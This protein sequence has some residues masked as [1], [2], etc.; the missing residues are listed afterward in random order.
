MSAILRLYPRAWRE[1][2]GDELAA[3]LE[4]HPASLLDEFDLIRGALDARLHP[5]VPG[6]DVAPEQEIPMNQRLLGI[7][8]AIGGIAWIVGFATMFV[9]PRESEG[10]RNPSLAVVGV[11]VAIP[12]IGI[13]LGMLGTRSDSPAS[14]RTGLIVA[15]ISV[16]IAPLALGLWPWFVIPILGFPVLTVIAAVRGLN[17]GAMSGWIALAFTV[18]ALGVY[19]GMGGLIETD[20]GLAGFT[21]LGVAALAVAWAALT[22]R[23][24]GRDVGAAEANAA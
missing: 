12:L 4:D 9:L 23:L 19:A 16:V 5:Q 21:L 13:A 18:G 7:A 14:S 10:Y 20:T 15:G 24:R 11:A 8:A 3:L 1:R 2:Y 22:N 6:T 17:N